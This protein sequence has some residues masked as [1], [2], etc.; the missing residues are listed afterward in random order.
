M[1]PNPDST[2]FRYTNIFVPRGY[3]LIPALLVFALVSSQT[4]FSHHLRYV[5]PAFPFV[6]IWMGSLW[7]WAEGIPWRRSMILTLLVSAIGCS[8]WVF[9]HSHAYFN[10]LVGGPRGGHNH[11]VDSNIEWG[12]DILL[13]ADWVEQHPDR[14]LDGVSYSL[15]W[16]IDR[17]V[18]GLPP[19]QPPNGYAGDRIDAEVERLFGPQPGRYAIF[20]MP[21]RKHWQ[22]IGYFRPF[23]PTEVLGQTVYIYEVSPGD[24]RRYWDERRQDL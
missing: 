10:A 16:L 12:Q 11:L 21:L 24:V 15:D 20:V 17:E 4:G 8:L 13:L 9:P 1:S 6:F 5:L 3:L 18:L 2:P 14:P 22:E 23:E 7:A 19:E